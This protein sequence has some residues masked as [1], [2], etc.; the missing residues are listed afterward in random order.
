MKLDIKYFLVRKLQKIVCTSQRAA[1][2]SMV[3]SLRPAYPESEVDRITQA[4]VLQYRGRGV[5]VLLWIRDP[6]E[7][8]ACAFHIFGKRIARDVVHKNHR[9]RDAIAIEHM[10]NNF[11]PHW[12]PQVAM[13]TLNTVQTELFLPTT[14][15]AFEDLAD[16]WPDELPGYPLLWIGRNEKRQSWEELAVTLTQEQRRK[17]LDFYREDINMHAWA[18]E[19]GGLSELAS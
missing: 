10:L 18:L 8:F 17:L 15:Y 13:H 2:A 7:R 5:P 16:T 9:N 3:E 6:L 1:S 11:N 4:E 12:W 14:I 19:Q